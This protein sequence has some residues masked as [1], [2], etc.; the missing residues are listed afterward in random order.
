VV[1]GKNEQAALEAVT[2]DSWKKYTRVAMAA[3]GG[4]PWVGSVLSAAATLSSEKEQ[5]E[6]N[7][8]MF[9]W[10]QEHEQKLKELGLTL[11][12]VFERF[13]SLGDEVQERIESDGYITLVRKTFR[14]W[15]QAETFEKKEMLKKL[16]T[17]SGVVT[18]A[19]DDLVRLFLEWIEKYHEFHFAVIRE[20]YRN[21]QITRKEIWEN[22]RGDIPRD[23]SAEAH[24][25]KLLISDLSLG[26]V[27]GQY[28]ETDAYGNYL[29]KK[30][31]K[32]TN[33]STLQSAFEDTKPY[34]LTE[35]GEQFVH[36]VMND[37]AEQLESKN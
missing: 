34:V 6:T 9:L 35:L 28:K 26:E 16:I 31:Q 21:P 14:Q 12:D 13:D 8:I 11:G 4:I 25:F 17:N 23:D 10:V 20:I 36:Y 18:L 22:I 5:G 24:L 33:T 30:P 27:I 3:L 2:G 19:Q 32:R 29:K 1:L 37:V 15:D 7:R